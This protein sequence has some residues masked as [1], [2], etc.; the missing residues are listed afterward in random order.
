LGVDLLLLDDSFEVT[1]DLFGFGE[2][3]RPRW[4]TSI[5]YAFLNRLWLLGG[6][7]DLLSHDRRDYFV[8]IRLRFNDQDLKTLL[9]FA[10]ASPP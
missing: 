9:P 1:Q 3:V 7:D 10:P 4:R 2:V 6:V 5:G 8:G